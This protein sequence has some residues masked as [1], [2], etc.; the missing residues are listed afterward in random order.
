[1][2]TKRILTLLCAGVMLAGCADVPENLQ[3]RDSELESME[4]AEL[5]EPARGD[6]DYIRSCLEKDAAKKYGTITVK[7]ASAGT[8]TE[9]PV[10]KVEVGGGDYTVKELAQYLY[11]DR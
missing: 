1:M 3:S 5:A 4:Q 7:H 2:K 8:A 6:L 11:G 10:Y 9:M